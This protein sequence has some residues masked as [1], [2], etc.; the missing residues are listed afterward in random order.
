MFAHCLLA[1]I[2]LHVPIDPI[3]VSRSSCRCLHGSDVRA[4][5]L[6]HIVHYAS[7][8]LF[9]TW[10][11][12]VC[13]RL[14]AA[15]CSASFMLSCG[16]TSVP[17]STHIQ[18]YSTVTIT[19]SI[20]LHTHKISHCTHSGFVY[21]AHVLYIAIVHAQRSCILYMHRGLVYCTRTEVLYIVH[22]QRSCILYM[23]RG[24][25]Y[26]TRTEVLYIVH[27]QRSC[28]WHM[29]CILYTQTNQ[30]I[31]IYITYHVT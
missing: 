21:M 24:L 23:H 29:S 22:A 12:Q 27:A 19:C 4:A 5:K 14:V 7:C 16:Q 31:L 2:L 28:I 15:S 8:H 13:I 20:P 26:C 6:L 30:K 9:S 17:N 3:L 1:F 18:C 10:P 25:V 11:L